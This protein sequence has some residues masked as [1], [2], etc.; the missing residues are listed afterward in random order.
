MNESRTYPTLLNMIELTLAEVGCPVTEAQRTEMA[1]VLSQI[2]HVRS[3]REAEALAEE[4][5]SA[6]NVSVPPGCEPAVWLGA[7][8]CA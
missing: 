2:D 4:L 6:R 1:S 3:R 7:V 8:E 5:E